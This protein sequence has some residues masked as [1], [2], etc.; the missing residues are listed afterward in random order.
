MNDDFSTRVIGH[1]VVKEHDKVGDAGRVLLDQKNAVH[2]Q[3][4]ARIFARALANES[5]YFIHRIAFGNGGTD[6]DVASNIIYNPK[7]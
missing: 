1:V 6:I 4:M 7:K 3:N 2:P 5:N